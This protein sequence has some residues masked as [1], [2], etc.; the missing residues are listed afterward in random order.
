[1]TISGRRREC[2]IEMAASLHLGYGPFTRGELDM[3]LRL[4]II[5]ALLAGAAAV[6]GQAAAPDAVKTKLDAAHAARTSARAAARAELLKAIDEKVK[7]AANAGDLETLKAV[8]PQK[9]AFVN[10]GISPT[11]ASLAGAAATYD[12]AMR[13]A[14]RKSVV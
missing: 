1:M 8:T 12:Q 7:S 10:A 9:D 2:F 3:I 13:R 4:T 5:L 14:D 6:R 11:H